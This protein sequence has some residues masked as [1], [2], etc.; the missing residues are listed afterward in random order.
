MDPH[1]ILASA[2]WSLPTPTLP[3]LIQGSSTLHVLHPGTSNDSHTVASLAPLSH[4]SAHAADATFKNPSRM[5]FLSSHHPTLDKP[6]ALCLLYTSLLTH[7][8][9]PPCPH[10]FFF[11]LLSILFFW[12][13]VDLQCGTNLCSFLQIIFH[14]ISLMVYY[15][16]LKVAPMLYN[17]IF[18]VYPSYIY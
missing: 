13:I 16:I 4:P 1:W 15:R 9:F 14:V 5:E 17:R 18:V 3:I 7:F 10:T 12:S 6:P 8:P 2:P 11:F